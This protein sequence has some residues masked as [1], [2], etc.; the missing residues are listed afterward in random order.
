M[1]SW[2]I[3]GTG[4][5]AKMFAED[6]NYVRDGKITA[7]ASRTKYKAD[8]FSKDYD[9]PGAY[10]GYENL[11]KHSDVDVVYIATPHSMHYEN[12]KMCFAYNKAVVCEKPITVN[13]EQLDEV[14][15]EAKSKGLFLMEAMW[16][17]FLPPII[18]VKK[19]CDKKR[20]GDIH[21]IKAFF[22]GNA[23]PEKS[24]R[25]FRPELAGGALLDLG[26]YPVAFTQL[27]MGCQMEKIQS[28]AIID[29]HHVDVQN[30]SIIRFKSG[31]IASIGSSINT[32]MNNDAYI[33]GTK[34]Y[35]FIP[36]FFK[37]QKAYL[38]SDNGDE[39][40]EDDRT[41]R[42]FNFEADEVNDLL[43]KGRAESS[44]MPIDKSLCNLS[45]IDTIREQIKLT[46]PFE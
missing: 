45:V 31:A 10:E 20:I 6:F 25:L 23:N 32:S 5:M 24:P 28:E 40:F 30:A 3:L 4:F 35:I 29:K 17:Y 39:V 13:T 18:Q 21:F 42:G 43:N 33:Y 44:R 26:I 11:V 15:K 46:Y 38:Y 36:N 8:Q 34:G 14:R 16:T 9:I 19:W 41:S 7:V 22:G 12:I 1:I 27:I 2:G 37:A